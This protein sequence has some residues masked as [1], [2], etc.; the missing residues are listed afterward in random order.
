MEITLQ[1]LMLIALAGTIFYLYKSNANNNSNKNTDD[2]ALKMQQQLNLQLRDELQKLREEK[3]Y[4]TIENT[5][6]Q[7]I[8]FSVSP[9]R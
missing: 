9:T 5:K 8:S 2:E 1:I 4:L 3:E 7:N 6:N